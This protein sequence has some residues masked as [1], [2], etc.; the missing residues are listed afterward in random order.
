MHVTAAPV[1]VADPEVVEGVLRSRGFP[2][3]VDRKSMQPW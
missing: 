1:A 3:Q 2:D